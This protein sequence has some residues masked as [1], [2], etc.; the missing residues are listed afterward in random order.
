MKNPSPFTLFDQPPYCPNSSCSAHSLEHPARNS[1]FARAGS[2]AVS[3]FPYR[4]QRFRCRLCGKVFSDSVF[5]LFYRDRTEPTYRQIFHS[6]VNGQSRR[7]LAKDLGCSLDTVQRRFQEMARQG[8]LIQAQKTEGLRIEE[9]LAYDGIENFAFSQYDPN[10]TNHAVGRESFFIYDF[11]FSP[12][13]RKG[14]MSLRQRARKKEL[15]NRYGAYP[16]GELERSSRRLFR[17]LREK[18]AGELILHTDNHYAYRRALKSLP[19]GSPITHLITPAK[20]CRNYRNRL[21]AI[22]HTDLLTR[23]HLTTFK[24]ETIAFAKHSLAMMESFSLMMVWKNFMRTI[25][26]KKHRQDPKSNIESPAVRLGIERSVLSFENFFGLRLMPTQVSLN[27]DWL[28][29]VQRRDPTSRR[30]IA[31]NH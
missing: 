2:R 21:F 28:L 22:N 12:L 7:N 25:F 23:H 4:T 31:T 15:E 3:R 5:Y 13:N 24:R 6:H 19:E 16:R 11:N 20:V 10:N 29:F 1:L 9:A 18:A 30:P 8:L 14:R 17:R 27:E 26:T